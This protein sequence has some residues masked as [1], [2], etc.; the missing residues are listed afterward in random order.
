MGFRVIEHFSFVKIA[1]LATLVSPNISPPSI[2]TT[3]NS[4]IV[5]VKVV[6]IAINKL[7]LMLGSRTKKG[8]NIPLYPSYNWLLLK[9]WARKLTRF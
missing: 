8:Y 2:I 1:I 4:P 6:M 3:P 9:K 5:C 7:G